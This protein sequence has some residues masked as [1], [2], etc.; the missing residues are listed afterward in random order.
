MRRLAERV[1]TFF[2]NYNE[3]RF[4]WGFLP[5]DYESEFYFRFRAHASEQRAD[6][7]RLLHFTTTVSFRKLEK[8]FMIGFYE[9]S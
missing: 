7:K 5:A 2:F 6:Q 3:I 1:K 9:I 4:L 8:K